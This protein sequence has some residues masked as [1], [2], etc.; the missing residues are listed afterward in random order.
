MEA[1]SNPAGETSRAMDFP[2]PTGAKTMAIIEAV[3]GHSTGLTQ[4]EVVLAT[5]C[6]VNLVFRVLSTLCL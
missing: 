3:G 2:V 6:S 1:T 5:G 4:F